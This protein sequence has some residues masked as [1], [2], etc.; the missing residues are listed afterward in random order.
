MGSSDTT[1]LEIYWKS[2][3]KMDNVTNGDI[4]SVITSPP[5]FNLKDYGHENQ[6]GHKSETYGQYLSRIG[7]VLSECHKK[8]ADS[9]TVWI[10]VDTFSD[11]GDLVL[12][13][14]H[15]QE[16]AIELG[17]SLINTIVWYKPTSIAGMN[18]G[19]LV[20]KK[21]YILVLSKNEEYK[22]NV[23]S[24]SPSDDDPAQCEA[25]NQIGDIWRHPVKKGSLM[26][27]N[28]LHKAPFPLS[29]A[30]RIVRISS[31]PGDAVLDPFLG[32]GTTAKAALKL[33]REC[34]GYEINREFADVVQGRIEERSKDE[35]YTSSKR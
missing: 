20:N 32:S 23:E 5:Y 1:G 19:R 16:R 12:L 24:T 21:E 3:E 2:S 29:V 7:K 30:K 28:V 17:Y 22:L 26:S 14:R 10:V 6:I 35:G 8:L 27:G 33:N 25:D 4:Q 15:I 13:P 18:P 31:D 9:G 34:I 11:N